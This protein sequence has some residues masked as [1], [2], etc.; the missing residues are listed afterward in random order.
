MGRPRGS[1]VK[2]LGI[3][4]LDPDV[5]GFIKG[6]RFLEFLREPLNTDFFTP[7]GSFNKLWNRRPTDMSLN[8]SCCTTLVSHR[9]GH[10]ERKYLP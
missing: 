2:E 3:V 10:I 7:R 5:V 4:L 8:R 6:S 1:K 9:V